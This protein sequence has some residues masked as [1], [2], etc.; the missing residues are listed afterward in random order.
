MKS[1]QSIVTERLQQALNA[2]DLEALSTCFTPDFQ[3]EQPLHPDR[4]FQGSEQVLKNWSVIFQDVPDFC[5]EVLRS[6]V[7]G[8]TAWSEWRYFGTRHNGVPL[9]MRGVSI[10]GI[11][12]DQI[13][14]AR[15]YIEPVQAT[16]GGIDAAVKS[17]FQ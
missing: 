9:D 1:S 3:G 12:A 15:L 2:H 7:V 5:T 14:W 8:D 17:L 16:G 11:E 6:A 10:L 4:A 13:K